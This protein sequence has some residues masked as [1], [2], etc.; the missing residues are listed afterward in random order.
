MAVRQQDSAQSRMNSSKLTRRLILLIC[1]V[2]IY[3][4]FGTL[5]NLGQHPDLAGVF[6][7][8]AFAMFV[9]SAVLLFSSSRLAKRNTKVFWLTIVTLGL[10]IVMMIFD[11]IG[12][13]DILFALLNLVTLILFYISRKEFLPE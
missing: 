5:K 11:Q 1:A 4:G 8:Y 9:E 2:L 12:F 3:F 13:I 10:N 7:F 6:I